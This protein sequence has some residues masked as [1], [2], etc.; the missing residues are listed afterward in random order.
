MLKCPGQDPQFWKP[1]DVVE[2]PCARCGYKVEFFKTDAR[3]RCPQCDRQ[4]ANPTVNIGC[5]QWC[6]Q[7][8]RCLGF[9]PTAL[10]LPGSSGEPL[11]KRLVWGLRMALGPEDPRVTHALRAFEHAQSLLQQQDALPRRVLASVLLHVQ[12]SLA[13]RLLEEAGFAPDEVR[14]IQRAA[15]TLHERKAAHDRDLEVALKA[16]LL[17]HEE[18][19]VADT[20]HRTGAGQQHT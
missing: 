18:G 16:D 17:T 4:V 2:V 20:V 5:A 11:V 14:S 10:D 7:A 13:P 8:S 1:E 12:P 19:G 6:E 3:L 9:E 15:T